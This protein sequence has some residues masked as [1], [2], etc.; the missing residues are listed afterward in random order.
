[1]AWISNTSNSLN[2][3]ALGSVLTD[4][5]NCEI[6]PGTAPSYAICKILYE[7]HPIGKKMVDAP[8]AMAQ[9]QAR[10]I[11][12]PG[13]PE[14]RI[15][16]VFKAEWKAQDGDKKVSALARTS[17]QYGIGSFAIVIDGQNPASPLVFEDLWKQAIAINVLDPLNTAGSIAVL[18]QDPN[19]STFQLSSQRVVS[20]K[21][22]HPSRTQVLLNESPIYISYTP[23]AFGYTGRSVYQRALY[24]LKSFV[25]T[26]RTDDLLVRKA[27]ENPVNYL[28]IDMDE[29]II[30]SV[31]MGGSGGEDRLTENISLNFAK[32]KFEYFTQEDTGSKGKSAPLTWDIA[33]NKAA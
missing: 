28:Q 23:S 16:D 7:Y 18:N 19:S 5:L 17:R 25:Q 26:M 27:G 33:A 15:R 11:T 29:I 20:G 2:G 4:M 1:M 31:T 30:T 10:D 13:G 22:Y 24:P 14:D 8:I 21:T 32:F 9:S 12:I 6:Q 3:T